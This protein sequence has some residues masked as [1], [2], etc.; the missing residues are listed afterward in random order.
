MSTVQL[1]S[2]YKHFVKAMYEGNAAIFAGAGL[3]KPSGF[4]DRRGLL[5]EIVEDLGLDID[6]ES[7][8]IAVA[9]YHHNTHMNRAKL[10]RLIVEAFT[11]DT[12]ISEI[13]RVFANPPLEE[14]VD[15][16]V[17]VLKQI[18]VI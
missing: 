10:D 9:Q 12:A 4:V 7:D 17:G 2:L 13:H 1:E 16:V 18:K 3:S 6:Q 5:K 14:L 15:A 11:K 8:L